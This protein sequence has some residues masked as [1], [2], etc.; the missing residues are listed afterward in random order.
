MPSKNYYQELDEQHCCYILKIKDMPLYRIGSSNRLQYR[1]YNL[2]QSLP[3]DFYV[4]RVFH[5]PNRIEARKWED[6]LHDI[7]KKANCHVR[8]SWYNSISLENGDNNTYNA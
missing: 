4:Y 1:I 2:S 8:G 3:F 7:L 5:F 6:S